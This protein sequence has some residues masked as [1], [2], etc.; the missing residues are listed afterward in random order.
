MIGNF[1]LDVLDAKIIYYIEVKLMGLVQCNQ[2]LE[3]L[4]EG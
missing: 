1:L 2:G 4:L 3:V